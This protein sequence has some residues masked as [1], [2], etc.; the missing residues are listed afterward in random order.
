VSSFQLISVVIEVVFDH[1]IW[2]FLEHNPKWFPYQFTERIV[3]LHVWEW[4][5]MQRTAYIKEDK[6]VQ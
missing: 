1:V 6:A 5:V 2:N 4:R 3:V